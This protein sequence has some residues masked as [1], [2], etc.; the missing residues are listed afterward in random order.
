MDQFSIRMGRKGHGLFLDCRSL[1]FEEVPIPEDELV[2]VIADSKVERGLGNTEYH[3]RQKQCE[4]GRLF[5]N[6]IN[7][8]IKSLR[9]VSE[10]LLIVN[11]EKL[12]PVVYKR[13]RHVVTE[14]ARVVKAVE[15]LKKPDM[16]HFGEMMNISH[17]SCK[18][19]FEVSCRE[20]DIL[21]DLARN[22]PGVLGSRMTGAGFGGCTI[23]LVSRNRVVEFQEK[24]GRLYSSTTGLEASFIVTGPED[25]VEYRRF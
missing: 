16:K 11:R 22:V 2:F 25:G 18:N 13:C 14:N 19:D 23:N 15:A 12:D 17:E 3:T 10:D 5:F 24:V 1:E 7:K 21:V 20:L 8:S 4:R 6:S 9:D